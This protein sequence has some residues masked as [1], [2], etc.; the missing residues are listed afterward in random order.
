M[1]EINETEQSQCEAKL[2]LQNWIKYE[3]QISVVKLGIFFFAVDLLLYPYTEE[4][5]CFS[6]LLSKELF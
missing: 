1:K 4:L 6:S 2:L 3:H 5:C